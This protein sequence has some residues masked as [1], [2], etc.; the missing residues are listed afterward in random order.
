MKFSF[1]TVLLLVS[2][3][4]QA[5][6]AEFSKLDKCLNSAV[7]IAKTY[8]SKDNR[9]PG[10]DLE[11]DVPGQTFGAG[12]TLV[13]CVTAADRKTHQLVSEDVV[14]GDVNCEE[15]ARI[16]RSSKQSACQYLDDLSHEASR[17]QSDQP[18]DL[19]G[20]DIQ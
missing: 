10:S 19:F 13:Y 4:A 20:P 1:V 17:P 8:I 3:F 6:T 16:D 18:S 7:E 9:L 15:R 5:Q 11:Y 14:V 2:S 12:G